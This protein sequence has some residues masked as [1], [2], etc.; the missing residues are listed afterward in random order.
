MLIP[1]IPQLCLSS[2][3]GDEGRAVL[4]MTKRKVTPRLAS[5]SPRASLRV[6]LS[7]STHACP[8][9]KSGST[10]TTWSWFLCRLQQRLE[11]R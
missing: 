6:C 3:Q 11:T 9:C 10:H 8:C 2:S 1:T 4:W 5:D 7:P